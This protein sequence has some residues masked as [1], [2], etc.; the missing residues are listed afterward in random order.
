MLSSESD[1]LIYGSGV[2]TDFW[3]CIYFFWKKSSYHLFGK[4][5]SVTKKFHLPMLENFYQDKRLNR[6][7]CF[8]HI[9]QISLLSHFG[10]N[11]SFK[12]C[13]HN[14]LIQNC[15]SLSGQASFLLSCS[16]ELFQTVLKHLFSISITACVMTAS[17]HKLLGQLLPIIMCLAISEMVC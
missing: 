5:E 11:F 13:R 16:R 4:Y 9:N 6:K 3:F 8:C 17:I 10:S 7:D 14:M 1:I 15:S 12:F 2:T